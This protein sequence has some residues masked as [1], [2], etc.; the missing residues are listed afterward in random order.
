[1]TIWDT[2]WRMTDPFCMDVDRCHKLGWCRK[3]VLVLWYMNFH[4]KKERNVNKSW[5]WAVPSS[6]EAGA[7]HLKLRFYSILPKNWG[8]LPFCPKIEGVFHFAQKLGSSSICPKKW[9]RLPFCPKIEVVFHFAKQLRSSSIYQKIE[10]VFQLLWAYLVKIHWDLLEN[11]LSRV[12]G[13][14]LD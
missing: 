2:P 5:G 1:M 3:S 10:V 13:G 4:L 8:Y 9:G 12:G 11:K 7:S 14:W 6:A